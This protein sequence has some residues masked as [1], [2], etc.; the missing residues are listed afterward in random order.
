LGGQ[1]DVLAGAEDHRWGKKWGK[2]PHR[3]QPIPADFDLAKTA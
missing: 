3:V 1:L 2:K